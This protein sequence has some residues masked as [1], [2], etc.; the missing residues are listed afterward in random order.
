MSESWNEVIRYFQ[1]P[2]NYYWQW[3]EGGHVIEWREGE[4]ICYRD[5]LTG[6]LK[7]IVA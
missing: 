5:E 3:V 4:T 1:P 7:K 2:A 6:V